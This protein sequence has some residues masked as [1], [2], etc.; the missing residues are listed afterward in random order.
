MNIK[1][2]NE[3]LKVVAVYKDALE[4]LNS[5][6]NIDL[7]SDIFSTI[8]RKLDCAKIAVD[9]EVDLDN[10]LEYYGHIIIHEFMCIANY[11]EGSGR[12]IACP[13]NDLRPTKPETLLLVSFPSGAY[14]LSD[15]YQ[16]EIYNKMVGEIMCYNP[17]YTDIINHSFYFAAPEAKIVIP[18]IPGMVLKY[19][20]IAKEA[21][22]S[23]ELLKAEMR[24]TKLKKE[25]RG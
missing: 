18:A 10:R 12:D 13:D 11:G 2:E 20:E 24:V 17:E 3:R 23:E 4:K 6:E 7:L 14:V 8:N 16:S 22:L 15:T 1:A 19:R 5:V 25:K 21:G 9:F